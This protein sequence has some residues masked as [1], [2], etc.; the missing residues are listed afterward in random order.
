LKFANLRSC[1]KL[2]ALRKMSIASRSGPIE[3]GISAALDLGGH[4]SA[5]T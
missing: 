4:T 2:V 3:R 1:R 5:R